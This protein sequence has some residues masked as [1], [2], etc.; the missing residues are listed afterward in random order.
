MGPGAIIL[1]VPIIL[2]MFFCIGFLG[3][4]GTTIIMAPY[5]FFLKRLRLY[6]RVKEQ[7]CLMKNHLQRLCDLENNEKENKNKIFAL[8]TRGSSFLCKKWLAFSWK[9]SAIILFL[10]LTYHYR[11]Q[12]VCL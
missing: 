3:I 2:L 1:L 8:N 6:Y 10:S 11:F 7:K 12:N 5:D 4:L 9:D